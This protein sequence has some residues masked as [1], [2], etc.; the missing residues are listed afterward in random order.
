MQ[1]EDRAP[2]RGV[3]AQWQVDGSDAAAYKVEEL[4]WQRMAR[5]ADF[6]GVA[7]VFPQRPH[8]REAATVAEIPLRWQI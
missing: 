8:L 4:V 1:R 5:G 2:H 3:L 6:A 7:L